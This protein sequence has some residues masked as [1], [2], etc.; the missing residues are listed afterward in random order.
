MFSLPGPLP[1]LSPYR[2]KKAVGLK[3]TVSVVVFNCASLPV[4]QNHF[5]TAT[6]LPS[7]NLNSDSD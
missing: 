6:L 2:E 3:N 7:P 4:L 1:F 5:K